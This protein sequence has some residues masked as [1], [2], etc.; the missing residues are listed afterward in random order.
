MHVIFLDIHLTRYWTELLCLFFLQPLCRYYL[1]CAYSSIYAL[2]ALSE[3]YFST[4]VIQN[5]NSFVAHYLYAVH[6]LHPKTFGKDCFGKFCNAMFN[7]KLFNLRQ[8]CFSRREKY[9]RTRHILANIQI[10]ITSGHKE[11]SFLSLSP[12]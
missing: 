6:L 5:L 7:W 1:Q 8:F 3:F 2:L 11:A 9:P 12:Q 4:N 10:N